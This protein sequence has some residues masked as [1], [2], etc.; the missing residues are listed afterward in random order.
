ME[1]VT[2]TGRGSP[3]ALSSGEDDVSVA[4][5]TGQR[6]GSVRTYREC[7]NLKRLCGNV[8]VV[9]LNDGDLVEKPVG[10]AVLSDIKSAVGDRRS[11]CR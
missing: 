2:A 4:V 9:G 8:L 3:P 11:H 7:P 6:S 10:F 1:S 5:I